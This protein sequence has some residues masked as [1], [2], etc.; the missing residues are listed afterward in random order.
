MGLLELA[1]RRLRQVSFQSCLE[2]SQLSCLCL[3]LLLLSA[4]LLLL[5]LDGVEHGPQ[6]RIVVHQQIAFVVCAHSFRNHLLHFLSDQQLSDYRVNLDVAT[7]PLN[8][9]LD[10]AG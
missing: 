1:G 8:K 6:N 7:Y 9:A 3:Q 4:N 2:V 10:G 5:S